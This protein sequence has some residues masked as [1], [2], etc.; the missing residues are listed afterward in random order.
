MPR[1]GILRLMS[2]DPRSWLFFIL[3]LLAGPLSEW[4]QAQDPRTGSPIPSRTFERREIVTITLES[5]NVEETAH[6]LREA[7]GAP[8]SPD[9]GPW[10]PVLPGPPG[11]ATE[12]YSGQPRPGRKAVPAHP[13]SSAVEIDPE[14]QEHALV[15]KGSPDQL[16]FIR[17][18]LREFDQA[19]NTSLLLRKVP[20]RHLTA[21]RAAKSIGDLFG[22]GIPPPPERGNAHEQPSHQ[23]RYL[24]DAAGGFVMIAASKEEMALLLPFL[25]ELDQAA[26]PEL[27]FKRYRLRHANPLRMKSTLESLFRPELEPPSTPPANSRSTEAL[28]QPLSDPSRTRDGS[29]PPP[30]IVVTADLPAAAI[31]VKAPN[32]MVPLIDAVILALDTTPEETI[33]GTIQPPQKKPSSGT[34]QSA[35]RPRPHR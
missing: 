1:L 10:V 2:N 13:S 32:A 33:P 22:L 19:P 11:G 17:S 16:S 34:R 5:K 24:P 23:L 9:A 20:L 29:A 35:G 7:F 3:V 14:P 25:A 31:L 26:V 30:S 4:G 21:D 18:F 28:P 12:D 8:A 15:V 27:T 6:L